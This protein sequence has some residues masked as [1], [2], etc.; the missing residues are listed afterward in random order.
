LRLHLLETQAPSAVS[1]TLLSRPLKG[2]LD[3][4][5]HGGRTAEGLYARIAQRLLAMAACIW[6]SWAAGEAVKRSLI[7]GDN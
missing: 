5:R 4:E 1:T 3:L 6:H 2:Q 7:A